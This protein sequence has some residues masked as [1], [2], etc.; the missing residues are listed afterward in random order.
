MQ[1]NGNGFYVLGRVDGADV[2]VQHTLCGQNILIRQ[3]SAG[4]RLAQLLGSG[5]LQAIQ[6]EGA[7]YWRIPH[8][9]EVDGLLMALTDLFIS[10]RYAHPTLVQLEMECPE[11]AR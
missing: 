11:L 2:G 4:Q 10:I 1:D 9:D 6:R 8:T 7:P 5:D 3:S